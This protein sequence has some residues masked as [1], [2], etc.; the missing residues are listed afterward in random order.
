MSEADF[1]LAV[2][3]PVYNEGAAITENFINIRRV[4]LNDGIACRFML[5]DDVSR[6]DTLERISDLS[7]VYEDVGSIRFARNFG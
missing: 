3:I 4:L 1:E 5:V 7:N 2:I 6:D